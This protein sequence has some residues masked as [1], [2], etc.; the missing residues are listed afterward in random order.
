MEERMEDTVEN[1]VK[2]IQLIIGL[3]LMLTEKQL[4]SQ[5]RQ[6][7]LKNKESKLGQMEYQITNLDYLVLF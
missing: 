5:H 6:E 4:T 1:K 7:A 3:Q 2:L